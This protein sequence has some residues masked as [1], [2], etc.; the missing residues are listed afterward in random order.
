[1]V[2]SQKQQKSESTKFFQA[3]GIIYGK[4][5]VGDEYST[6]E[7]DGEKLKLICQYSIRNK[8]TVYLKNNPDASL[9][10]RVY[11]KFNV[12]TK[13]LSFQVVNFYREQPKQTQINQ[14]LLAGVWQYVPFLPETPVMSI[15]RNKLRPWESKYTFRQNHL[16]I[17]GFNERAYN[18][19]EKNTEE[20]TARK[21]YELIA[22]FNPKQKEWQFL[23]LLDSSEKIPR[24]IKRKHEKKKKSSRKLSVELVSMNF[25]TLQKTA[26]KLRKSGF[27]EGN[28]AGKG[29]TKEFLITRIQETLSTRPEA[30][31]VLNF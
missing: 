23:F 11:P 31:K 12:F 5:S 21:F 14:F 10:L 29:V 2:A 16:P 20:A 24:Y 7:I 22:C 30:A 3:I 15:Y 27:L 19:Q 26:A 6:V 1:M 25:S 18:H 9:Y 28:I 13:E 17:N 4:V 8:L